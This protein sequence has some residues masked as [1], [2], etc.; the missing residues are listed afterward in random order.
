MMSLLKEMNEIIELLGIEHL[1]KNE[2]FYYNF[3]NKNTAFIIRGTKG[4]TTMDY[5][6]ENGAAACNALLGNSQ[7]DVE[8]AVACSFDGDWSSFEEH[9]IRQIY[10][11]DIK[12]PTIQLPFSF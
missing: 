8:A 1:D 10:Q 12:Y 5:L 3:N 7:E 6:P 9:P 2:F 4:H 11:E